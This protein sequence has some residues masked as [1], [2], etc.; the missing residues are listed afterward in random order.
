MQDPHTGPALL[1]PIGGADGDGAP[2]PCRVQVQITSGT[3]GCNSEGRTESDLIPLILNYFFYFYTQ[4][5]SHK[6]K[7]GD[8]KGKSQQNSCPK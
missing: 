4:K 6:A 3:K 1:Q 5:C 7:P 2:A 8:A